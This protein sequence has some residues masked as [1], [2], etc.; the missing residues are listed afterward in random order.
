MKGFI[1]IVDSYKKRR[2]LNIRHIEEVAERDESSCVIYLMHNS[3]D[4]VEQDYFI[5]QEPYDVIKT[6]LE[7]KEGAE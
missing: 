4:S 5:V 6:L 3:P 2:L 7:K 1:E